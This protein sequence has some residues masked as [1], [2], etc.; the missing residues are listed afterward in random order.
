MRLRFRSSYFVFVVLKFIGIG[1]FTAQLIL[2]PG[3]GFSQ[4]ANCAI[5]GRIIDAEGKPAVK[6]NVELQKLQRIAVTDNNGFFVL[7][8]LPVLSDTLILSSIES[9]TFSQPVSLAKNQSVNLGDIHL[10]FNV[11][12]LA[13]VEVKGR[14]AHSYK[15]DYSFFGNKTETPVKDIPQSIS[16]VT[17]ELIH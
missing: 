7:Q 6:V 2:F 10:S 5:K 11:R 15:S 4:K 1:F 14:V 17:K 9:K 3:Y 12:Q 13:D 8:H 16:A